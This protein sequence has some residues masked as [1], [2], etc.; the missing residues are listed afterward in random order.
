MAGEFYPC[1]CLYGTGTMCD[2]HG[3]DSLEAVTERIRELTGPEYELKVVRETFTAGCGPNQSRSIKY[4]FSME[5]ATEF[6]IRRRIREYL[7]T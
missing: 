7:K 2:I 5:K 4:I 3:K 6:E 1:G